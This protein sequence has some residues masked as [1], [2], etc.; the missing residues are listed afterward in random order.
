MVQASRIRLNLRGLVR[1]DVVDIQHPVVAEAMSIGYTLGR[2]QSGEQIDGLLFR[3]DRCCPAVPRLLEARRLPAVLFEPV[4][5]EVPPGAGT[6]AG[7]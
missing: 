3:H 5:G 4:E 2:G 1:I 6:K 7:V